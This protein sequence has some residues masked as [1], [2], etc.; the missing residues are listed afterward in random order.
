MLSVFF[1]CQTI[2][3]ITICE[4]LE[5]LWKWLQ[6]NKICPKGNE[7]TRVDQFLYPPL[8]G[9]TYLFYDPTTIE[10]VDYCKSLGG[11]VTFRLSRLFHVSFMK[12][13]LVQY[14]TQMPGTSTLN[15]FSD[16]PNQF[17]TSMGSPKT[18]QFSTSVSNRTGIN[19]LIWGC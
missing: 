17:Q 4:D 8:K 16:I 6:Q 2:N 13:A 19:A 11:T 12:T 14:I 1:F 7:V 9:R 15:S 5:I 10:V 18:R 3:V